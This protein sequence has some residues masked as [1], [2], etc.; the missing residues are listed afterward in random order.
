[1]HPGRVGAGGVSGAGGWIGQRSASAAAGVLSR[2]EVCCN[3][4]LNLDVRQR[5]ELS[6]AVEI[7][8][9]KSFED[10]WRQSCT[11]YRGQRQG[12]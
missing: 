6:V 9:Q 5:M 10:G 4:K 7:Q 2:M 3:R 12:Q 11:L 8:A 1:M